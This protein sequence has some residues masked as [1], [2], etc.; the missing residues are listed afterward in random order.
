MASTDFLKAVA[1]VNT[2]EKVGTS[3]NVSSRRQDEPIVTKI[4]TK[5][6]IDNSQNN[7]IKT[8]FPESPAKRLVLHHG[9]LAIPDI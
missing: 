9:V 7:E 6:R 5:M 2:A 3:S 8:F 4:T 1:R